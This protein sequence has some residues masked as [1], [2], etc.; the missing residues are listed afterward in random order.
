MPPD[1][2]TIQAAYL[3]NPDEARSLVGCTAHHYLT[4]YPADSPDFEAMYHRV[5]PNFSH[6]AAD[7]AI[8]KIRA[9]H[10]VLEVAQYTGLSNERIE[11]LWEYITCEHTSFFRAEN[12]DI[13]VTMR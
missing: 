3:S 10:N 4:I 5:F 13:S 12:D 8:L 6:P 7:E 11:E 1:F 9:R 2:K